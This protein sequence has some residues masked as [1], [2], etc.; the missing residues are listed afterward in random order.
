MKD[1]TLARAATAICLLLVCG[2]ATKQHEPS[3]AAPGASTTAGMGPGADPGEPSPSG[4]DD[5][6]AGAA[7]PSAGSAAPDD[8]AGSGGAGEPSGAA[9]ASVEPPPE[10]VEMLDANTDWTALRL[11]FPRMYSA[12]DGVHIFQVPARVDGVTVEL[13]GWQAIP[14]SAVSFDPDPDSEEGGVLITVLEPVS[15][16]TIAA[17]SGAV[18]GTAPLY[19]TA[20]TPEDWDVGEARY[21]NGIEYEMPMINLVDL[22]DPNYVPPETPDNLACNNCHTTGA[23]YLEIQ[24]TPSQIAYISDDNLETILLM[25]MKPDGITYSVLPPQ[26]EYLYSEFHTWQ[27]SEQEVRGLIVY[28]RSLTPVNQGEIQVP[29]TVTFPVMP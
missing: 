18:G 6:A 11:I 19:I 3:E 8:P 16:V 5:G 13:E 26:L 7:Q 4:N 25:G 29:D 22:F 9:G 24:H 10:V 17:S 14:A 12:H 27:A 2:C 23:K 28:L 1:S 21:N 20:A 15:E